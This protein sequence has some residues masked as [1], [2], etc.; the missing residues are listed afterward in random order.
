MNE[1]EPSKQTT[2]SNRKQRNLDAVY[3]DYFQ[4]HYIKLVE[5]RI[6]PEEHSKRV[7]VRK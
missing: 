5:T 2:N 6:L 3:Q 7:L 4:I 1:S